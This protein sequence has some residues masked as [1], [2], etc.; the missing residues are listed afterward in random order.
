MTNSQQPIAN[1][2]IFNNQQQVATAA[3]HISASET[4]EKVFRRRRPVSRILSA[5]AR[6]AASSCVTTI[7][8]DPALLAGSSSLPGGFG[9]AV[10]CHQRTR[11]APVLVASLFGL[12]PCGVLPATCLTAGAVR[13]YR[14]FSPLPRL[15]GLRRL[16]EAVF[17]LCHCPSSCPDR[18]L[19]G[20]LPSGVRTFLPPS[21]SALR[22]SRFGEAGS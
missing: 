15:R 2:K 3:S 10:L 13:S 6:L 1:W 18:E 4:P 21:H 5:V 8:L 9:R 11:C 22:A 17:F 7:P 19:P 16:G 20:A 12:A 14:T